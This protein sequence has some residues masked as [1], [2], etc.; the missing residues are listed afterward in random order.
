[1]AKELRA[2][3]DSLPQPPPWLSSTVQVPEGTTSKPLTVYYRDS[4]ECS[5]FLFG[6]PIFASSM[7]CAP[8][9]LWETDKMET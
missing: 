2:L 3:V 7:E 8:Y 6:N 4:L 9:K 1:M 5:K